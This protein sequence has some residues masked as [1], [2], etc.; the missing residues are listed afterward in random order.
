MKTPAAAAPS[1]LSSRRRWRGPAVAVLALVVCSLLV[2][3]AFLFGRFPAGYVTDER[4]QQEINFR[5][6]VVS[7]VSRNRQSDLLLLCWLNSWQTWGPSVDK[8]MTK[9]GPPLSKDV[10]GK[11]T[12]QTS[13]N[14]Q[15]RTND[16]SG[17]AVVSTSVP[18]VLPTPQFAI[19]KSVPVLSTSN[20]DK[21]SRKKAAK[22]FN[23]DDSE[24]SCQLEFGSYCLWSIE[25]REV[26][27]DSIV[28]RLKDQLFVAR[29]YYPSI[30]KL[31]GQETLSRELKQNIQEHERVLSEAIL[32]ADLPPFIGDKIKRMDQIIARAKSCTV[33]C[34]NVDKKL[35]QIL[36]MAEDE[37]HFHM[38]QSAFL[39][40]L[41][42]LHSLKFDT[43][44]Y[45]HYII[46]SRNVLAASVVINS[47]MMSSEVSGN[48]VFHV[49]TDAQ[50]YYAMKLW[51]ARSSYKEAAIRVLD[52]E[53]IVL[54]TLRNV[55]VWQLHVSEEFRITIRN[56]DQPGAKMRVEYLAVFGHS[57]FL[58]PEI[59][60]KL[61]RVVILD[62]DVIVQQD[63]SS[64]W[65]IN[66]GEK[67]NGAVRFC[68][69]RLGQLR[70]YLGNNVYDAKSCAW[71]SGL[72][73]VD[74]EKWRELNITGR[75]MHLLQQFNSRNE[76]SL[77]A[78]ALPISLLIFQNLIYPLDDR[79]TISG[80]GY[81]Y[82]INEDLVTNAVSLHYN[83]NMKPWLELGIPEYK[84]HWKK[85]L[86][87][88]NQFMDE[89]NVHL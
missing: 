64:L 71:M 6:F 54:E 65:N 61:K 66:L 32:D 62:D 57:H 81:H 72:N 46:F 41:E 76:V 1:S 84:N 60:K 89:C 74:F 48:M 67:V 85:F 42:H 78:S 47:T 3:L 53:K 18:Q 19:P 56:I 16:D 68:G 5:S 59:F 44:D 17:N 8:L 83:G 51:F 50:N 87:R 24:K 4:L 79:W 22:G 27:Q 7:K 36:D 12:V 77:R 31:H 11:N 70:R 75:Y 28:K 29:A 88:E 39:H 10:K 49:L 43:P 2:P 45:R 73:I 82:G 37:A 33:D 58:L 63:L 52:Y 23:S 86:T 14:P 80:L 38:K 26:M 40:H 25:H 35:R 69:V 15:N 34:N 21:G 20:E 9:V 55:D 13:G 30:A